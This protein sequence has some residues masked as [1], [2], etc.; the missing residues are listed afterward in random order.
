MRMRLLLS[1]LIAAQLSPQ[2][3]TIEV[4]S[5]KVSELEEGGSST[6]RP[7]SVRIQGMPLSAILTSAFKIPAL[8]SH[9]KIDR[10]RINQGLLRTKFEIQAN[11]T[12]DPTLMLRQVLE[13]RFRLKWHTETRQVPVLA[14][15]A[16]PLKSGINPSSVNC[17]AVKSPQPVPGE[18]RSGVRNN[19]I[20]SRWAGTMADLAVRLQQYATLPVVDQTGLKGNYAWEYALHDAATNELDEQTRAAVRNQL[21][22]R[23]EYTNGPWEVIVI[24]DARMPTP[25]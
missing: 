24:D 6:L 5:V 10:S 1:V 11:G 9:V 18:C 25:N 2:E 7:G 15:R 21:G 3:P 16:G 8:Q 19:A 23:L 13:G 14:L 22:L 17:N 12:G 4:A 20:V